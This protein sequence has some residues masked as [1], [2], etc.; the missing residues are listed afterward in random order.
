[1]MRGHPAT[2]L[3]MIGLMIG[4]LGLRPCAAQHEHHDPAPQ[5]ESALAGQADVV[6]TGISVPDVALFNQFGQPVHFYSDLV[7]GKVVA[8]N[9]IFTT[10]TTICPPMGANY[11]RLQQLLGDRLGKEVTLLSISTDPVTDTP[12]RLAAWSEQF[13]A[14]PGWTL[15]TGAKPD[16]DRL[17]K[18]LGAFAPD[19]ADHSPF[20][21]LGDET[22]GTWR[23]VHGFTAPAEVEKMLSEM[24]AASGQAASEPA[25][26]AGP[27]LSA[28][29]QYFTNVHL[30]D[31]HGTQHRLYQDLLRGK[32]VIIH[33]FFSSCEGSCP[34]MLKTAARLQERLGDRLGQDVHLLSI[35]VDPLID[36]PAKLKALAT[37]FQAKPGWYFLTGEQAY[38][39]QALHKFGQYVEK[40]DTHLNI[41]IIGNEPTGLW[42]KAFGLAPSADIAQILD[43]VLEDKD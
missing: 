8:I 42:K 10:C 21:L 7:R 26:P 2:L 19:P 9:F 14:K 38:V 6:A 15:V 37:S 12:E 39:Q 30:V 32:V 29:E 23:R 1:M 18:A 41:F 20:L 33:S 5:A 22:R 43:D 25:P 3:L 24:L 27:P 31:Q 34:L 35:S 13:K 4:S 28:A 36:T 11:S 40:R 16:V 17:L